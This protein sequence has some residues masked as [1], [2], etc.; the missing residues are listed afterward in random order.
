MKSVVTTRPFWIVRR[1][2]FNWFTDLRK[3]I[4]LDIFF[5]GWEP[6]TLR[7]LEKELKLGD[8]VLEVGAN[9]GAHTLPMARK[10]GPSG[11]ILAVEPTV[12]ATQ[13]LTTNLYLNSDISNVSIITEL[14][15]DS[16][17]Q[18]E[19]VEIQSDWS[20]FG[21]ARK[22]VLRDPVASTVD[23]LLESRRVDHI[24]LLK[25]DVDGHEFRVISG[26]CKTLERCKPT[27]LIEL[28]ETALQANGS[29]VSQLHG[30]LK[31][32]GFV[33]YDAGDGAA[34]SDEKVLK[35]SE[36]SFSLN[37]VYRPDA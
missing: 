22:E 24:S 32:F 25:I 8:T 31:T 30:L 10:V 12:Y 6:E 20:W 13:R 17:A 29:S 15:S 21:E 11:L 26:A 16:R 7:F 33:A 19:L 3:T 28:C 1:L 5:G 34:L 9:I 2:G 37:V 18:I 35:K 4:D 14:V 27:V 36:D 23:H